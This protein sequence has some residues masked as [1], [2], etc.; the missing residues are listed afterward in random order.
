MKKN[1]AI[2]FSGLGNAVVAQLIHV[3]N[4][5]Y[6]DWRETTLFL[7]GILFTIVGFGVLFRPVEFS[8]HLKNKNSHHTMKDNRLPPSCMTSMEK[9]QRFINEMD[10][11]CARRQAHQSVSMSTSNHDSND[12]DL[13]NSYSAD[14]IKELEDEFDENIHINAY[15]EKMSTSKFR[16]LS[17]NQSTNEKSIS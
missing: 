5:Y 15:R 7:S 16:Y 8:L 4:D 12:L 6:D 1:I 2:L 10:K 9:L 17:R 3:L 11:Q 14:D 13:V